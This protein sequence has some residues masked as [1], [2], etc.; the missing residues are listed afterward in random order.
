[1]RCIA[2]RIF[3]NQLEGGCKLPIAV[4]SEMRG[5]DIVFLKGRVL[6]SDGKQMVEDEAEGQYL[7]VGE[8]LNEKIRSL[9]GRELIA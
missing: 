5:E 9:G 3:L 4:Y 8:I 1:M 2:E 6:S 7:K